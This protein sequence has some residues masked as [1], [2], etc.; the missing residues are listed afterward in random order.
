MLPPFWNPEKSGFSFCFGAK[1][2][3][4]RGVDVKIFFTVERRFYISFQM[5]FQMKFQMKTGY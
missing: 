4:F 3:L 1:T 2:G 5:N